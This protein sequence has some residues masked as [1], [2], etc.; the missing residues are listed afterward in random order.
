MKTLDIS[1]DE[2]YPLLEAASDLEITLLECQNLIMI[3][4]EANIACWSYNTRTHEEKIIINPKTLEFPSRHLEMILRHE[5]LHKY[6]YKGYSPTLHDHRLMNI[7]EDICINRLLWSVYKDDFVSFCNAIYSTHP[8]NSQNFLS[9]AWAGLD[10]DTIKDENIRNLYRKI[11]QGSKSPSPKE[12]YF[13]LLSNGITSGDIGAIEE[14]NPFAA[15]G[16][17]K[18]GEGKGEE[19][20]TGE[21][22]GSDGGIIFRDIPDEEQYGES[23]SENKVLRGLEKIGQGQGQGGG[24][25][26]AI[27]DWIE[28]IQVERAEYETSELED[29]LKRIET[30]DILDEVSTR[31]INSISGATLRQLYPYRLS[32]AGFVYLNAGIS[33]ILHQYWNRT[34]EGRKPRLNIYV[35]TSPSMDPFKEHE[36]FLIQRFLDLFPTTFYVFAGRV[37]EFL[38]D[39]FIEGKY[40][41]GSSTSFDN[42]INHFT[43]SEAECGVVFTDGESSVSAN[44]R[45]NFKMARKRLFTVYFNEGNSNK[46]IKSDLDHISEAVMQINIKDKVLGKRLRMFCVETDRK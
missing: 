36:V 15:S 23:K 39:D 19:D 4:D 34:V 7:A 12:I 33:E 5:I 16:E 46:Q 37:Q 14:L 40:P 10:P 45:R 38:I 18:G 20:R 8:E 22:G 42:V 25:S 11:W 1:A 3:G 31:I 28:I 44:N 30:V 43:E 13:T 17:G 29:F 35:D 32:R 24:F 21:Q 9:L 2:A 41:S 6:L 27:S 26:N